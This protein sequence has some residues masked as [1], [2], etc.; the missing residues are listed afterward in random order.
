MA[1]L[2]S[3]SLERAIN[4][5]YTHPEQ[6]YKGLTLAIENESE[7]I[8]DQRHE[9]GILGLFCGHPNQELCWSC[10]WSTY[11]ELTSSYGSRVKIMHAREN[12]GVW[13]IGSQWLLR[14]Q[15]N[16]PT[17]GNDYM[18]QQFLRA[19]LC[20]NVPLVKEMRLLSNP[21]DK[22]HY[23]LMSRAQGVTLDSIWGILTPEQKAGYK[24][25]LA[26]SIR[27]IRKFT[28]PV[29]KKV[30]GSALDDVIIGV[31]GRRHPPTCKKIGY[32]TEEW[33]ENVAEELRRGLSKI[34]KTED[35]TIIEAKL[36][37][38]KDDFP[39]AEPYVLTHADL[40]LTNIIV[41]DERI[42]AIIDWE[43]SG[44]YPWWAERWL[45]IM[46][47]DHETSGLFESLWAD[48]S[49]ELDEDAFSKQVFE[50]LE[51]VLV[52]W[53]WAFGDISHPGKETELLRPGFCQC[54]PYAG[55]FSLL[56]LGQRYEHKLKEKNIPLPNPEG[57]LGKWSIRTI[58]GKKN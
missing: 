49:P 9:Q 14:D 2:P 52:A 6:Y 4:Y 34:H 38:L 21:E 25:Q 28:S 31:C 32:T 43:M 40:N 51:P 56:G 54:K 30:D 27:Q 12:I 1:H 24:D 42:E 53:E 20:L 18:T 46:G 17:L 48:L 50:K 29:A 13:A 26:D 22:I 45:S 37:E 39:K 15:P 19:Q 5:D 36:Q 8:I 35:P 41:K 47:S 33:F 58:Q 16:D 7:E 3:S 23:T 44:Y 57:N 10:G 55:R 11:L